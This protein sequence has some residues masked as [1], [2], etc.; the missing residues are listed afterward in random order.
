MQKSIDLYLKAMHK[1]VTQHYQ[2]SS[3]VFFHNPVPAPSLFF[4][5][6]SDLVATADASQ[7][8]IA[9][10]QDKMGHRNIHSKSFQDS[11]HVS[12]MYKHRD[13]YMAT[14]NAFLTKV[15]YFKESSEE[16]KELPDLVGEEM[17]GKE[18]EM[19]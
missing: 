16:H 11:P 19:F 8:A 2:K 18:V 5:S 9:S 6:H 1:P 7:R 4:Y 13:E 15:E 3:E 12:H 14:L 17:R 10:L